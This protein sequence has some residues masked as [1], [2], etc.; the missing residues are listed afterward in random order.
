AKAIEFISANKDKP[1]FL[2]YAPNE[3]H[4]PRTVHP[5]FQG[6]TGLGPRGDALVIFDWCVGRLIEELKANGQ[7]ENTLIVLSS[8]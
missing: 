1:F 6:S 3:T 7:Y 5:R 8:D 4:V 2:Y